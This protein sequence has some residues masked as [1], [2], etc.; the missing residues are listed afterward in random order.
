M[1]RLF[2][3]IVVPST[4]LLGAAGGGADI[5]ERV[6]AKVN[7]QIITL[8]DFQQ[9][10]ITAA[11]AA[12]VEPANVAQF[13]RQNNA[14]ILQDAVDEILILQKAEDQ[15]LHMPPQA[16]DEV[17]ASIKKDNNLNTE[18]QFQDALAREGLTLSELRT[19]IEHS[20]TRRM[21][22]QRDIEP[23][24]AV[25]E[26]ELRAEYEKR[27]AEFTKPATVSLQEILVSEEEGGL[28]LAKAVVARAR[29]GED[30][31]S[32][33]RTYS[34]AASKANGGDIG[35]IPEP[36]MDQALQKLASGVAVGAVSDPA[37]VAG[38]FRILKVTARTALSVTPFDGA[39]DKL[40]DDIMMS[41]FQKEYDV[42]M[43]DLRKT[44]QIELRVREVPL[45]LTGPIP[46]G[47]LL[48]TLEPAGPS[49]G[50]APAAGGAATP[51]PAAV[52]P[53]KP[54]ASGD[55]E[56]S[57]TPQAAPEHLAPP[58]P[59]GETPKEAKPPSP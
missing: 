29:A 13:L 9:R 31:P 4:L 55:D 11:Q 22:L 15:G 7:G 25:S 58:A 12:H 32:L 54:A 38:G 20:Y 44:A 50:G 42:Y 53:S 39:K 26:D 18:E 36:D 41:R 49:L 43:A 14:R 52:S 40:R 45:R 6:V 8:S 57:V 2:V 30:F 48:E 46:E 35:E 47:S 51:A 33:A 27:K 28:A 10:Q 3:L 17:I 24:I 56:I 23:R 19:N 21:V 59:P 16:I 5:I 1:R 34:T 37:P